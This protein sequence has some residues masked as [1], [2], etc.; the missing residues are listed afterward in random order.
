MSALVVLLAG[1][2]SGLRTGSVADLTGEVAALVS[3]EGRAGFEDR[4]AL[5]L[6]KSSSCVRAKRRSSLMMYLR[7]LS[8]HS[9]IRSMSFE[10]LSSMLVFRSTSRTLLAPCSILNLLIGGSS[11]AA[12]A[13]L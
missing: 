5:Y 9:H 1:M 12:D 8:D 7:S 11:L 6:G 2:E 13:A 3:V 4:L 10:M